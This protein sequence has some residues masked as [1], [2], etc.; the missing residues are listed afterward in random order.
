MNHVSNN[1]FAA[2]GEHDSQA[3][4]TFREYA[5]VQIMAGH[6]ANPTADDWESADAVARAATRWADALIS[7]LEASP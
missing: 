1:A 2:F 6:A 5:A 7:Q 4:L 3:G